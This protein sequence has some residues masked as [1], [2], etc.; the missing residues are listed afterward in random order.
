MRVTP[1]SVFAVALALFL[2]SSVRAQ[3]AGETHRQAS[4][5]AGASFG[6][7]ETA[8]ALSAALA[9]DLA[10]HAGVELELAY[11]RKLDFTLDLCPSPRVCV[12]GGHVPV[13]GRTVALTANLVV[14]LPTTWSRLRPYLVAGVGV[15]HLRQRYWIGGAAT[16]AFVVPTEFTRSKV[17][18]AL[19]VGAGV[20]VR[21]G[22]RIAVGVDVRSAHVFDAEADPDRFIEP[23]GAISTLRAGSRVSWRF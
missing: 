13:T 10:K 19:S 15:A 9:F 18:P 2:P 22:R 7:G 23:A 17:A 1:A 20:D 4:F 8:P 21:F 3:S 6:D 16:G 14:D 5:T 12:L 11:A